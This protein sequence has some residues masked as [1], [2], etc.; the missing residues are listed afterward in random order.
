[1]NVRVL[2][3]QFGSFRSKASTLCHDELALRRRER[4]RESGEGTGSSSTTEELL[5][6]TQTPLNVFP[7]TDRGSRGTCGITACLYWICTVSGL[8]GRAERKLS[9]LGRDG[10]HPGDDRQSQP[11]GP[12]PRSTASLLRGLAEARQLFGINAA[13]R[14]GPGHAAIAPTSHRPLLLS[15]LSIRGLPN[16]HHT[17]S[18]EGGQTQEC[19]HGSFTMGR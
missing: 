4:R 11:Q 17:Q 19:C 6:R 3:P 12:W 5:S 13:T 10:L 15:A 7:K 1:M 2:G 9:L 14:S 18:H 16:L 8:L